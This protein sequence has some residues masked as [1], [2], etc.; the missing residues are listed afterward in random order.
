MCRF[1][2]ALVCAIMVWLVPSLARADETHWTCFATGEVYRGGPKSDPYSWE[3]KLLPERKSTIKSKAAAEQYVAA[4][5]IDTFERDPTKRR[6][7][8]GSCWP[9]SK[10]AKQSGIVGFTCRVAVRWVAVFR[11]TLRRGFFAET[12]SATSFKNDKNEALEIATRSTAFHLKS[13][14]GMTNGESWT[15]TLAGGDC[16]REHK[17]PKPQGWPDELQ[18]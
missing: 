12:N 8:R 6:N 4:T 3:H 11:G 16:W 17:P 10:Q 7:V 18:W 2:L 9:V 5:W 1:F 14:P 13:E 15:I